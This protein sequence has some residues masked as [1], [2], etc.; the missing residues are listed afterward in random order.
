MQI[1]SP[2][3]RGRYS[4]QEGTSPNFWPFLQHAF[5]VAAPIRLQ[6]F[7]AQPWIKFLLWP[8]LILLWLKMS[9]LEWSYDEKGEKWPKSLV[10]FRVNVWKRQ[11][12]G[13]S[14]TFETRGRELSFFQHNFR[15]KTTYSVQLPILSNLRSS[16][17]PKELSSNWGNCWFRI[18][19]DTRAGLQTGYSRSVG[20]AIIVMLGNM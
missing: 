4:E 20:G 3:E 5:T 19:L 1:C 15:L 7:K 2:I 8:S 14:G 10:L 12:S 16:E 6:T 18:S 17:W 13:S 9:K 11:I